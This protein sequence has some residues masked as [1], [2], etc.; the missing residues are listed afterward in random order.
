MEKTLTVYLQELRE[1]IAKDLEALET[2]TNI[3]SDWYAASA[4]TKLAAIAIVKY[5]CNDPR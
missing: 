5:G 3:S 2:P 4:R 1:E